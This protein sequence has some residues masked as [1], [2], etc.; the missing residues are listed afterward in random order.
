MSHRHSIDSGVESRCV[1]ERAHGRHSRGQQKTT[2]KRYRDAYAACRR[3]LMNFGVDPTRRAMAGTHCR[4]TCRGQRS[5]GGA[6]TIAELAIGAH[7]GE[8]RLRD[9]RTAPSTVDRRGFSAIDFTGKLRLGSVGPSH[10]LEVGWLANLKRAVSS[11]FHCPAFAHEDTER[12]GELAGV[13]P[14]FH[15]DHVVEPDAG[16]G[17]PR[18]VICGRCGLV[19]PQGARFCPRCAHAAEP[20]SGPPALRTRATTSVATGRCAAHGRATTLWCRRCEMPVCPACRAPNM[21]GVYCASCAGARKRRLPR[22]GVLVAL[23]AVAVA[24][25][26]LLSGARPHPAAPTPRT[27]AVGLSSAAASTPTSMPTST[28]VLAVRA[29]PVPTQ[30]TRWVVGNTGGRGVY[31]RAEPKLDARVRAWP[32]G[33]VMEELGFALAEDGEWKQVRAPDGSVGWVPAAYL[34]SP[35][36]PS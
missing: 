36:T 13:R 32:D 2:R 19:L 34:V 35:T 25:L 15:S 26:Y 5:V 23:A 10:L 30:P 22:R 6:W 4:R 17:P 33:T 12:P 18:T 3:F 28:P 1:S 14:S 7:R 24:G 29:T 20:N 11:V 16:D 27:E 31:V 9:Q 21:V 8:L